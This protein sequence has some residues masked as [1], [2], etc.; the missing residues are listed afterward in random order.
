MRFP[1]LATLIVFAALSSCGIDS[2]RDHSAQLVGTWDLRSV[3]GQN[4]TSFGF[5]DWHL[6][7]Q[8]GG[9]LK[10]WGAMTGT[11]AGMQVSGKGH[12]QL[13]KNTLRYNTEGT[14]GA[15]IARVSEEELT[16]T[17]DPVLVNPGNRNPAETVYVR[18]RGV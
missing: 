1:V 18:H 17:P 4:V 8:R 12:W 13:Q 15:C 7:F 5:H 16:L 14:A 3:A 6:E 9:T 10:Y 11:L 2:P